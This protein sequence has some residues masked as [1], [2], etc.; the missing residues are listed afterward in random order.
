[1][2]AS[3][4]ATRAKKLGIPLYAIAAGE[5]TRSKR[6]RGILE[7]L[8]Q[9]TGGTTYE[10]KKPKDVD[11]VFA[12]ITQDLQHLYMLSYQ[13]H[14]GTAGGRWRKI[15]LIVKGLKNYSIRAK[16]GYYPD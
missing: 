11:A 14:S 2:T 6:L 16:E 10:V 5:A 12:A 8:S 1:L 3:A 4:A 15:D 9:H 13:A 7:E